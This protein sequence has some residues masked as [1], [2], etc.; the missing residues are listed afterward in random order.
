MNF[1]LAREIYGSPWYMDLVSLPALSAL[2]KE[3]NS[4]REISERC[5]EMYVI[6]M[7]SKD[8]YRV[9]DSEDFEDEKNLIAV[10]ELNGAITKNGGASSD[11]TLQIAAR[12][13]MMDKMENV[14][15]HILSVES[16]GGS[17][18]AIPVMGDAIKSLTKP[19]VTHISGIG[20]SAAIYISSFTPYII[21]ERETD[22]IGSIGT[23]IELE[24]MPKIAENKTTGE[25]SVRIY[26]T[27][28]THKNADFEAAIND[29]NFTPIIENVLDP[30]NERFINDM[31][32]N[33][34]NVR[35]AELTG[36]IF[37][38]SE[39]V[40]TLIDEI[41][42]FEVAVNKVLSMSEEKKEKVKSDINQNK[43]SMTSNELKLQHPEV[44]NEI[45]AEAAQAER[46][47]IQAWS[48]FHSV[49]AEAV[50]LGI[51][52]G[53]NISQA[54]F[55]NF[56]AKQTEQISLKQ[57]EKDSAK[58]V[59]VEKVIEGGAENAELLAYEAAIFNHA[60]IT[61]KNK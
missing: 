26:A 48:A 61:K 29:H 1:K 20:A 21:A 2:L 38:A 54:D 28:S 13:M 11:G 60:G 49:D 59:V 46:E 35:K 16:G 51:E 3:L 52:S 19:I 43:K 17:V 14:V 30:H 36:K 37:E 10:H 32:A 7:K 22:K 5:N 8:D 56:A 33:R 12:M 6:S 23:M 15:G 45:K 42:S 44:Y 57:I 55:A 50:K 47:R 41:G 31:K 18:D 25:R 24:A 27:K 53:K 58:G 39:V 40:G 4:G 9:V 34:P